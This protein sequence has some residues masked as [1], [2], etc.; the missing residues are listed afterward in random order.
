ME[1]ISPLGVDTFSSISPETDIGVKG[2]G[3]T[4]PCAHRRL[5]VFPEP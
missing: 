2:Y 3:V 4:S 5:P 1:R